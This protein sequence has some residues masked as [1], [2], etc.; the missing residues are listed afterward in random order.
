M[1]VRAHVQL[2]MCIRGNNVLI[3]IAGLE[4]ALDSTVLA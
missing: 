2:T 4:G 3:R 1:E